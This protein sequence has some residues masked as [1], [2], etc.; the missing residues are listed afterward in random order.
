MC[1]ESF[2][3]Q[4]L[5]WYFVMH[6]TCVLN[7]L[8]IVTLLFQ[9]TDIPTGKKRKRTKKMVSKTYV[10]DEGYMGKCRVNSL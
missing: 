5:I 1:I 3:C 7:C 4:A 8:K 6:V 10:N 2:L 9:E